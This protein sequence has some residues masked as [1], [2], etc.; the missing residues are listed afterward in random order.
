MYAISEVV[1]EM[2]GFPEKMPAPEIKDLL[3]KPVES[4]VMVGQGVLI[5]P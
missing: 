1:H 2:L 3:N 4:K 5:L